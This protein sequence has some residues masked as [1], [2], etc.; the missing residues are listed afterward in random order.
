[1]TLLE[2]MTYSAKEKWAIV[3]GLPVISTRVT[4]HPTPTRTPGGKC[5]DDM[6]NRHLG[7]YPW[8]KRKPNGTP[9]FVNDR[10]RIL[11]REENIEISRPYLSKRLKEFRLN[12]PPSS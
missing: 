5:P 3:Y 1:M 7:K 11:K 8:D 10:R 4:A 2:W 9:F 6:L 12:H